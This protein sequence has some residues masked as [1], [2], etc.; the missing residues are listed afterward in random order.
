MLSP[1]DASV[2]G[3]GEAAEVTGSASSTK[4][5]S[6]GCSLPQWVTSASV[7][8]MMDHWKAFCE[9]YPY[10]FVEPEPAVIISADEPQVCQWVVSLS[11]HHAPLLTTLLNCVTLFECMLT[12]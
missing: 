12:I 11:L 3:D 4:G 10:F 5:P 7:T 2:E 8:G 9:E 1:A 6:E